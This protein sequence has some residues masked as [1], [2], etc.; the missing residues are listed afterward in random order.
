MI[1]SEADKCGTCKDRQVERSDVELAIFFN[2]SPSICR[3]CNQLSAKIDDYTK[4]LSLEKLGKIQVLGRPN[5][6]T[7][8]IDY[9]INDEGAWVLSSWYLLR[10]GSCC[11]NGCKNCPY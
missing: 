11:F 6:L 10:Q 7:E 1:N 4:K 2:L 8:N 3:I 9:S 5:V